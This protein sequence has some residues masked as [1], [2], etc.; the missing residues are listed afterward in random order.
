LNLHRFISLIA[1]DTDRNTDGLTR[2]IAGKNKLAGC[3]GN[4]ARRMSLYSP[5][6]PD[7]N[8]TRL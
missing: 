2:R 5:K 6:S 7:R 8:R 4:M 1:A 3:P